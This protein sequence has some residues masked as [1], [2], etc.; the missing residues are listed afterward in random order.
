MRQSTVRIWIKQSNNERIIKKFVR[1]I[2]TNIYS[3]YICVRKLEFFFRK[4]VCCELLEEGL[5]KVLSLSHG[6]FTCIEVYVL[7]RRLINHSIS[8]G[9]INAQ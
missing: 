7:L 9:L 6:K 4:I 5:A 1:N 2:L 8:A 3:V